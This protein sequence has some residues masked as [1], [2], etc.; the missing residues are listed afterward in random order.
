MPAVRFDCKIVHHMH[1][2]LLALV[3]SAYHGVRVTAAPCNR[4]SLLAILLSWKQR[5]LPSAAAA[6]RRQV[7]SGRP[8][9]ANLCVSIHCVALVYV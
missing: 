9:S 2:G 5:Y 3:T 1:A 4:I 7:V 6:V 8:D